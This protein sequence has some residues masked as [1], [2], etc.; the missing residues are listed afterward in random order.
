M[1]PLRD[2]KGA[3]NGVSAAVL[4]Q[5]FCTLHKDYQTGHFARRTRLSSQ[6]A[7]T[8]NRLQPDR[9]KKRFQLET[10]A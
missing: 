5:Q 10:F 9:S 8:A 6:L 2:I 1:M 7:R 4:I 3:F